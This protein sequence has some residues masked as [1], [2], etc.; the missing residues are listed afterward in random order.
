MA[1]QWSSFAVALVGVAYGVAL[2]IGL[3]TRGLSAPIVDPLLAVMEALR[4]IAVPDAFAAQRRSTGY[5]RVHT[6]ERN[7]TV[8]L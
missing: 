6:P 7:V 8:T 1:G 5:T 2:I 4:M 3:T